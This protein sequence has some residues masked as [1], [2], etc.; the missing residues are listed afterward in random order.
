MIDDA[1]QFTADVVGRNKISPMQ[2]S[3]EFP[4]IP[5]VSGSVR[6]WVFS[7]FRQLAVHHRVVLRRDGTW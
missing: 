1:Y 7:V 4:S 3:Q 5:E 2:D 6:D